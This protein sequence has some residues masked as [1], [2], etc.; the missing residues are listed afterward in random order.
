MK[1]CQ[2]VPRADVYVDPLSTVPLTKKATKMS[3][4]EFSIYLMEAILTTWVSLCI[5]QASRSWY[6]LNTWRISFPSLIHSA[7]GFS[8]V[9]RNLYE[10]D[11]HSANIINKLLCCFL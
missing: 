10:F 5:L 4:T 1:E 3:D 2:G 9:L 11:N 7:L 8:K 6:Q